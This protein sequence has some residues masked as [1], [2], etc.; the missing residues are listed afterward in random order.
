MDA[1]MLFG[2]MSVMLAFVSTALLVR[3]LSAVTRGTR[4]AAAAVQ[5]GAGGG[6]GW[7]AWRLRN[8]FAPVVPLAEALLRIARVRRFAS[9]AVRLLAERRYLATERSLAS[10]A[11][12]GCVALALAAGLVTQSAVAATAVV[13]CAVAVMAV[14]VSSACDRRRDAMREA[15]PEVLRS[16]SACFGAGLTLSQTFSQV[17]GEVRGPLRTSFA[18]AAHVLDTGGAAQEALTALKA[19]AGASELAFVAVALDVQ[20]QAG[21]SLRQ[22]LD[23]ARD[24]V[25]GELALRRSLKVQ[26]AQARL[27]ARVVSIMP[28]ALVAVFSLVSSDFLTPFFASPAGYALLAVALGMQAAGVFLVRRVLAA[29]AGS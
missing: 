23:A 16:L 15:V 12:V 6:T 25:E 22:V 18:H 14:L 1:S 27:S 19:D 11:L 3:S 29:G 9:E 28:F 24:S 8:G 17:A 13:A 26:T 2:G 10:V 5:G 20:H 21:G 4:D 7:L